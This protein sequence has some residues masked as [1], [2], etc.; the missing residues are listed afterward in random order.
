MAAPLS[1]PLRAET[2]QAAGTSDGEHIPLVHSAVLKNPLVTT[3]DTLSAAVDAM[4][5]ML[6]T[7][8]G[9]GEVDP[10]RHS[11]DGVL[12]IQHEGIPLCE[13]NKMGELLA[14]SLV[15]RFITGDAAL[16]AGPFSSQSINHLLHYYDSHFEEDTMLISVF[17]NQL[18]RHVAVRKAALVATTHAATL[19]KLGKLANEAAFRM[20]RQW[21][22]NNHGTVKAKRL[23]AHLLRLL[24][25]V[26]GTVPF[27]PFERASAHPK[28]RAIA[29]I[30]RSTS[31][32]SPLLNMITCL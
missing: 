32:L 19:T 1:E 15:T 6:P 7:C 11:D 8:D 18:Q 3:P 17:F 25:L 9:D 29:M 22:R 13:W 14:G 10:P 2:T 16:K 4:L 27:S 20:Q 30:L 31:S 21:A 23:N 24:S 12:T 28:L 26:G 5:G